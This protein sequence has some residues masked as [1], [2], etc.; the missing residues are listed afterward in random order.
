MTNRYEDKVIELAKKHHV[1]RFPFLGIWERDLRIK[2]L[3]FWYR[4]TT[5]FI[6]F[7]PGSWN[8]DIRLFFQDVAIKP[9]GERSELINGSEFKNLLTLTEDFLGDRWTTYSS[10]DLGDFVYSM[11]EAN[12]VRI[13]YKK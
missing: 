5:G 7:T 12:A 13:I 1:L 4:D 3:K 9:D 2:E 10:D 11:K 6:R 8:R